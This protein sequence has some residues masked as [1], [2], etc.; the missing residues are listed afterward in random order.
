MSPQLFSDIT[1]D[2]QNV[3]HSKFLYRKDSIGI[4]MSQ[5]FPGCV[6]HVQVPYYEAKTFWRIQGYCSHLLC[7]NYRFVASYGNPTVFRISYD[8]P[9]Q[10]HALALARQIRRFERDEEKKVAKYVMPS[11]RRVE[12]LNQLVADTAVAGSNEAPSLK[13]FQK[14]HHESLGLQNIERDDICDVEAMQND[15]DTNFISKILS[16]KTFGVYVHSKS[17]HTILNKLH[18]KRAKDGVPIIAYMDASGDIARDVT[19]QKLLLH[20][21]VVNVIIL[22]DKTSSPL[23]L[24][25]QYNIR[26]TSKAISDWLFDF[27]T[28]HQALYNN[29]PLLFDYIVSDFCYATFHAIQ[30]ALN[31]KT[32]KQYLQL[33]YM[34]IVY[35]IENGEFPESFNELVKICMC[36]V[37][38]MHTFGDM[39]RRHFGK[40]SSGAQLPQSRIVLEILAAMI[41]T[42]E[43]EILLILIEQLAFLLSNEYKNENVDLA[44]VK[45]SEI[46]SPVADEFLEPA[47]N[48]HVPIDL[49]ELAE[50]SPNLYASNPFY[51]QFHEI[52]DNIE[53]VVDDEKV[54]N[55]YYNP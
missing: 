5:L 38:I 29:P 21:L 19:D 42:T 11:K 9:Q 43:Y 37:H 49:D 52:L 48:L 36:Y 25:E 4:E 23:P 47:N 34:W 51:I 17:Q 44:V 33:C 27:K 3:I 22:D 20:A 53:N 35:K 13:V 8:K 18:T 24:T 10:I 46:I 41:K 16:K 30:L 6:I 31:S 26:Q 40:S 32:L 50:N 55:P 12:L 28:S 1:D 54:K 2:N 45:V 7:R 39:T 15:D 14:I